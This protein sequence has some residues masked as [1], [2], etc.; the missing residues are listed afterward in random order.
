MTKIEESGS[1]SQR[2]GSADPDPDPPLNFMDPQH[3]RKVSILCKDHLESLKWPHLVI[4]WVDFIMSRQIYCT[5]TLIVNQFTHSFPQCWDLRIMRK[6]K[7]GSGSG[8]IPLTNGSG[9]G[10]AKNMQILRIRIHNTASPL[11]EG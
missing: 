2:H 4:S 6:R 5:G 1:I 7:E 10:R 11:W 8:S 9:S 3:C